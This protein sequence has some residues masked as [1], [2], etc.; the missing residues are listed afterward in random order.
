M[1]TLADNQ[2]NQINALISLGLTHT[3]A[4]IYLSNLRAGRATAKTIS[5]NAKIARPDVYR[6]LPSLWRM[7]LTKKHVASPSAYEAIRPKDAIAILLRNKKG[8]YSNAKRKAKAFAN[9]FGNSVIKN[10][11]C[12]KEEKTVWI[13]TDTRNPVDPLL[14]DSAKKTRHSLNFTTRYNLFVFAMNNPALKSWIK[15]M[16]KAVQRGV[17]IRMIINKPKTGDLVNELSFSIPESQALVENSN[18]K[19]RYLPAPPEC[20][21]ITF[22]NDMCLIETSTAHDVAVSPYLWTSNPVL[23]NLSKTYFKTIWDSATDPTTN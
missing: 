16:Y 23:V 5:Q 7:G 21:L 4:K 19:Y 11:P 18:F 22:D 15:E 2:D 8:E 17:E 12:R 1:R 9:Y 6:V 10:N 3:Q 20:I 13:A 14:M